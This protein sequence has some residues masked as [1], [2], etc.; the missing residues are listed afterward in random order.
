[1]GDM[2]A[3]VALV[4]LVAVELVGPGGPADVRGASTVGEAAGLAVRVVGGDAGGGV[5]SNEYMTALCPGSTVH[6]KSTLPAAVGLPLA[7]RGVKCRAKWL[8]TV[9]VAWPGWWNTRPGAV[10]VGWT[11]SG[12]DAG[13]AVRGTVSRAV[14]GT[15][16][17]GATTVTGMS[18]LPSTVVAPRK[19]SAQVTVGPI[20]AGA[21][22]VIAGVAWP[23]VTEAGAFH[24]TCAVIG[25]LG[26]L[27]TAHVKR[28]GTPAESAAADPGHPAA[29]AM[30]M[31]TTAPR[32][33]ALIGS[34]LSTLET[35]GTDAF[36]CSRAFS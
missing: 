36:T 34:V 15:L 35:S 2:L 25:W 6:E 4:A 16:P 1:M 7:F 17:P 29:T 30:A 9:I 18:T 10:P 23:T 13:T 8:S 21:V 14:T 3:L 22:T 32:I 20:V 33:C 24:A 11:V 28:N 27:G 26:R 31:A 5:M 19:P 12:P